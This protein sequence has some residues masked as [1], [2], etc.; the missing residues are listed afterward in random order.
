M[1]LNTLQLT[2]IATGLLKMGCSTSLPRVE[3][4]AAVYYTCTPRRFDNSVWCWPMTLYIP[5]GC[6]KD[7]ERAYGSN[8]FM[9]IIEERTRFI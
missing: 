4:Q 6:K 9:A 3:T 7:Y 1:Q 2:I 5:K 8:T